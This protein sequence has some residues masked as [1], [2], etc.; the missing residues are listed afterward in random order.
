MTTIVQDSVSFEL[1]V[2]AQW[3]SF[4][5]FRTDGA[6]SLESVKNGTIAILQ[7][8]KGQYR[9]IEERDFQHML[10][11]ARDVDRL[12]QG[13]RV[14]RQSVRIVQKHRDT[15]SINLLI[16]YVDTLGTLPELPIRNKFDTLLPESKEVDTEDEV[17]L[18]PDLIVRPF[19]EK[20]V[21]L[22][23]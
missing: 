9:I 17:D 5:K 8:K 13:L 3:S 23:D 21:T 11:L 7:T 2:G 10:G 18:N 12:R 14:L 6:K 20:I 1:R 22:D 19:N 16:E 4:E 15:D